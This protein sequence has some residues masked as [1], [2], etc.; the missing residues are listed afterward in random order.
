VIFVDSNVPMY[1]IGAEHPNKHVA[2]R[3]V[4]TA[5]SHR[6]RLVTDAEV[7]QEIMHRYGAIQRRDAIQPAFDL[8]SQIVDTVLPIELSTVE[9]AH[10]IMLGHGLGARDAVHLAVMEQADVRDVMSFDADYDRYPAVRR[11]FS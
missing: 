5:I 7:F 2:R 11:L 1:L 9:Q 3:M 10:R 4:D 6:E 8:L